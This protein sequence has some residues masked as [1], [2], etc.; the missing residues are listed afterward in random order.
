ML[1]EPSEHME[2]EQLI[3]D[4]CAWGDHGEAAEH[5]DAEPDQGQAEVSRCGHFGD[6]ILIAQFLKH[7]RDRETEADQRQRSA[8]HRHQCP[9]GAHARA[10]KRHAGAARRELGVRI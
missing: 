4:S 6:D 10:L 7:L 3:S 9:V 2:L 5:H 8:D 1:L